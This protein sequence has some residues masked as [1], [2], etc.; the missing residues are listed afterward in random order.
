MTQN[1]KEAV[2]NRQRSLH[3][4]HTW[5]ALVKPTPLKFAGAKDPAYP[6]KYS[7]SLCYKIFAVC[8]LWPVLQRRNFTF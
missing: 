7:F 3:I 6:S 2:T 5:S 8:T 1:E 4:Q